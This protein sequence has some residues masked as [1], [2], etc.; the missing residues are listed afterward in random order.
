MAIKQQKFQIAL[1]NREIKPPKRDEAR[2]K[3]RTIFISGFISLLL[4]IA[5]IITMPLTILTWS[6]LFVYSSIVS[7]VILSVM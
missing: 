7:L 6:G 1:D 4:I 5:I 3:L 2:E